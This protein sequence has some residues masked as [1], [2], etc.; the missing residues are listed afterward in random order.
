ML[1]ILHYITNFLITKFFFIC[2]VLNFVIEFCTFFL[3]LLFLFIAQW[4]EK[5]YFYTFVYKKEFSFLKFIYFKYKQSRFFY[6]I[7]ELMKITILNFFIIFFVFLCLLIFYKYI[8]RGVW[9]YL[10]IEN[11]FKHVKQKL[12]ILKLLL[13]FKYP[14]ILNF[15][16]KLIFIYLFIIL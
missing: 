8:Q 1:K 11:L 12:F 4:P 3:Q 6:Q 5:Y 9:G 7:I 14:H 16:T 13:F 2:V 10:I 15:S